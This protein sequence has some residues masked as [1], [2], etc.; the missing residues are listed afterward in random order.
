MS[1]LCSAVF[2][3]FITCKSI[4]FRANVI[5]IISFFI[6]QFHRIIYTNQVSCRRLFNIPIKNNFF[7]NSFEVFHFYLLHNMDSENE[8]DKSNTS[9]DDGSDYE[10]D[11]L[12]TSKNHDEKS[13]GQNKSRI[14]K[15]LI[16]RSNGRKKTN[17]N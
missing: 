1:F 7:L 15:R 13:P 10:R 5:S 16:G 17:S 8:L 2:D 14:K 3:M 6:V 4:Q 11:V 12:K 9:H